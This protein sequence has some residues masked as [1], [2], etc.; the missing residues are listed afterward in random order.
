MTAAPIPSE[1]PMIKMFRHIGIRVHYPWPRCKNPYLRRL[2]LLAMGPHPHRELTLM[3]RLGSP[4][5]R[6]GMAAGAIP[7][8]CHRSSS[9]PPDI[10][11][12]VSRY[13]LVCDAAACA[14]S[15]P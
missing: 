4:C 5:P 8:P 15:A 3:P 12:S 14:S 11:C 13:C 7:R 6:L 10:G 9:G 2:F 1:L